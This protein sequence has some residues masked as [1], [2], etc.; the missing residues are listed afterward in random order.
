MLILIQPEKIT[1]FDYSH[2]LPNQRHQQQLLAKA[3]HVYKINK[4]YGKR[5]TIA[6]SCYCPS[7]AEN[8]S[9]GRSHG[10]KD[11]KIV[12]I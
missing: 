5:P 2:K 12:V 11:S 8:D 10:L 3:S 9:A 6:N 1:G 7:V 4:I